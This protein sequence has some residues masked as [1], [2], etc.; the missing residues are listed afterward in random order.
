[1]PEQSETLVWVCT[2][3]DSKLSGNPRFCPR[4]GY[5]VYRPT[6][7]P[8]EQPAPLPEHPAID[9]AQFQREILGMWPPDVEQPARPRPR[10]TDG[11]GPEHTYRGTCA[12]APTKE[13]A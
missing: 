2:R 9:E 5:T 12:Y 3:C 6:W 10:M 7:E 1:M 11:C 13:G 4:C 8:T